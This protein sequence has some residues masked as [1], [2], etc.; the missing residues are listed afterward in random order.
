M[1]QLLGDLML[2][3]MFIALTALFFVGVAWLARTLG[4]LQA[5]DQESQPTHVVRQSVLRRGRR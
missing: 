1:P 5:G 3:A 4:R 2:D